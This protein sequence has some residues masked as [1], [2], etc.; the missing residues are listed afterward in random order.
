VDAAELIDFAR[1]ESG[2]SVENLEYTD[3]VILGLL[4][5][6]M[7]LHVQPL[8]A[9]TRTGFWYHTLSRTLGPGNPYVR[10][11]ARACSLEQVDVS[12]DGGVRWQ[13][14]KQAIEADADK[15]LREHEGASAPVAFTVRGTSLFLLPAASVDTIQLRVKVTL[16][17]SKLKTSESAGLVQ[18]V[19]DNTIT[20]NSMP[21]GVAGA[22]ICDVIQPRD[23]FELSLVDAPMTVASPTT[24]TV[25]ST[26]GLGRIEAGD[27][28]RIADQSDWP[29]LPESYHAMLATLAAAVI[30]DQRELESKA[31]KLAAKAASQLGK[32]AA[33]IAP[34]VRS[35][36]N[37][38]V[39][40]DWM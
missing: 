4:N 38:P 9:S 31:N 40:H 11:P 26:F 15:W 33:D 8:I 27:Y 21:T 39:L 2:T 23:A 6:Q 37:K 12:V 16:R 17:P 29:Q 1:S 20:V 22:V 36:A 25:N 7:R 3:S 19:A 34:R 14:L 24:L 32:L 35:S 13:P 30:C 10:M 5:Q 28:V 18:S